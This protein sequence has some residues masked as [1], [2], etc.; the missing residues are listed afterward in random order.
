LPSRSGWLQSSTSTST[1][2]RF[3]S[4]VL[5][6]LR[7]RALVIEQR[8]EQRLYMLSAVLHAAFRRDV[9]DVRIR[10][11]GSRDPALRRADHQDAALRLQLREHRSPAIL[12][13]VPHDHQQIGL[14]RIR[15]LGRRR[16]VRALDLHAST[17]Q[18]LC[19]GIGE[20]A[21]PDQEQRSRD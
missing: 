3:R 15:G 7:P 18:R 2:L 10:F 12:R 9:C 4:P 8:P 13:C 6:A 16:A 21:I 1:T 19:Q 20:R 17:R 14:Q 5:R 11:L